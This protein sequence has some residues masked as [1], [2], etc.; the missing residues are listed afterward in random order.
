MAFGHT[1][2]VSKKNYSNKVS[3]IL[4]QELD[5]Q[6][7]TKFLMSTLVC[8]GCGGIADK[9]VSYVIDLYRN[10]RHGLTVMHKTC[11]DASIAC[12]NISQGNLNLQRPG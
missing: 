12:I 7:F 2:R 9:N 10:R 5:D 6:I 3:T 4:S 1:S 8:V 11:L